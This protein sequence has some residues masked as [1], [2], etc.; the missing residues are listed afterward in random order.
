MSA[1]LALRRLL[2]SR[3]PVFASRASGISVI[4][5]DERF[6]KRIPE[7]TR[8]HETCHHATAAAV[9]PGAGWRCCWASVAATPLPCWPGDPRTSQALPRGPPL[10]GT[11]QPDCR[12]CC[13]RRLHFF[14]LSVRPSR[15]AFGAEVEEQLLVLFLGPAVADCSRPCV[16]VDRHNRKRIQQGSGLSDAQSW[17]RVS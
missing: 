14:S 3:L 16:L 13:L 8:G 12:R 5:S 9:I 10:P 4:W 15:I 17:K 11:T 2:L 1:Q 7:G 6:R